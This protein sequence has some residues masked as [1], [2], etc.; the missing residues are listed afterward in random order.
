MEKKIVKNRFSIRKYSVGVGSVLL[1]SILVFGNDH[2]T[3]AQSNNDVKFKEIN[4]EQEK[5]EGI[6]EV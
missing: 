4:V 3:Y 1:G 2:V 6:K 5:G